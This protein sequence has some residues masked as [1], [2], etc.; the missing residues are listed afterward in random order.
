MIAAAL[1]TGFFLIV[2]GYFVMEIC[3][4]KTYHSLGFWMTCSFGI[5]PAAGLAILLVISFPALIFLLLI[6]AFAGKS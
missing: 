3:F 5:V 4:P 1:G 6:V 2:V